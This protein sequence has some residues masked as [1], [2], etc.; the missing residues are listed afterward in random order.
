MISG[1]KES[2]FV[3]NSNVSA[4]FVEGRAVGMAFSLSGLLVLPAATL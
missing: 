2:V 3:V 1:S 4:S